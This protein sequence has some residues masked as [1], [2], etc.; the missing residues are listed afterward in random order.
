IQHRARPQ[1][2]MLAASLASAAVPI[3][4]FTAPGIPVVAGLMLW[5]GLWYGLTASAAHALS[6]RIP[7]PRV[8]ALVGLLPAV[9]VV[10]APLGGYAAL[11]AF[12]RVG[13]LALDVALLVL[14][15][16]MVAW[17]GPGKDLVDSAQNRLRLGWREALGQLTVLRVVGLL[18]AVNVFAA[19]PL[20]IL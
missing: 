10:L 11:T 4:L 20:L 8:R 6:G 3:A 16:V 2:T 7:S 14:S 5:R 12:G 17:V 19:G 1:R 15:A 9:A 13:G 18:I